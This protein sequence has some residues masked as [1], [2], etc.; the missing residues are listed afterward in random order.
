M[1]VA[2]GA[3]MLLVTATGVVAGNGDQSTSSTGT[4]TSPG[5]SRATR[6]Y[7]D[8][9]VVDLHRSSWDHVRVSADG[10]RL[11]V[12]FWMGVQDCYGLGKVDTVR[13]DGRLIIKLWTGYAAGCQWRGLH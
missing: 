2:A 11:V 6:V 5:G 10:K 7:P 8:P 3:L 4:S 1:A 9:S 13:R 12:Y